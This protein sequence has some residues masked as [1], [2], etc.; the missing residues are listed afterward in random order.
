MGFLADGVPIDTGDPAPL[1]QCFISEH[2]TADDLVIM[3]KR[4]DEAQ[5]E[6][7]DLL[8]CRPGGRPSPPSPCSFAGSGCAS[9][10]R[11]ALQT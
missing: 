11:T 4:V 5:R 1:N 6:L 3:L 9:V 7:L 8:P 2:D 10:P